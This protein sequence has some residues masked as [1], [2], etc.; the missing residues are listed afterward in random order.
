MPWLLPSLFLSIHAKV[1]TAFVMFF[2]LIVGSILL[3][4]S[5][6]LQ[7]VPIDAKNRQGSKL[8]QKSGDT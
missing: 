6:S 5:V 4:Q 1:L 7:E 3:V 2:G 8:L